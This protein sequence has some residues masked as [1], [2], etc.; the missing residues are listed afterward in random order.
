MECTY[1]SSSFPLRLLSYTRLCRFRWVVCQ[2][3]ALQKC[4]TVASLKKKSRTLPRTL[5]DTY[6]RLRLSINSAYHDQGVKILQWRVV[7]Q[8]PLY[9][10]E[11]A[12]AVTILPTPPDGLP[13]FNAD[14]RLSN[15]ND[16]FQMSQPSQYH[17]YSRFSESRWTACASRVHA[18]GV[19]LCE[20]VSDVGSNIAKAMF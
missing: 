17:H 9:I 3:D 5:Y 14:N 18:I 11:A 20:R 19:L 4:L 8:R 1:L 6:D 10:E 12:E 13:A 16:V 2:L 15:P 7:S